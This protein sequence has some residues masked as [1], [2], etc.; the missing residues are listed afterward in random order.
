MTEDKKNQD[1]QIHMS[2]LDDLFKEAEA[3]V[4]KYAPE[5]DTAEAIPSGADN[6]DAADPSDP[7]NWDI[8]KMDLEAIEVINGPETNV[9]SESEEADEPRDEPDPEPPKRTRPLPVESPVTN[10]E[11]PAKNQK[12]PQA[13]SCRKRPSPKKW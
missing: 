6:T 2:G 5:A 12:P 11:S 9:A 8:E 13:K 7:A 4:D 3:S 1:H 10:G